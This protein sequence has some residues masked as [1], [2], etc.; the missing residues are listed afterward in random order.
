MNRDTRRTRV[1]LALLLVTSISL[2]TID[3][4]GGDDSP[5]D[6]VRVAG[7]GGVRPGRAG[8][9]GD[10]RARSATRSTASASSATA[11][12]RP[13]G[14]EARTRSCA[15]GCA[16]A[17]STGNRAEELDA[18]LRV[19]GA[20]RYRVVPAQVIAIG[21]GADLLLDRHASTPAAGTASGR[22]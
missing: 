3:Y 7:R 9:R 1:L 2:I 16:P 12:A 18:L 15:A 21:A 6:G 14:C 8:G 22:T 13:T 19:A 17:S 20:G 10:R 5:L 4:R 11:A